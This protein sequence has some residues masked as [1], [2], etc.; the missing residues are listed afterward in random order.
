MR[1]SGP[2]RPPRIEIGTRYLG[3]NPPITNALPEGLAG[4]SASGTA[5]ATYNRPLNMYRSLGSEKF[6]AT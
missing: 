4:K 6:A 5:I 3:L 1:R 2:D